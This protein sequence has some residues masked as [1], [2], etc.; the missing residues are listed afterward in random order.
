MLAGCKKSEIRIPRGMTWRSPVFGKQRAG[1][2]TPYQQGHFICMKCSPGGHKGK[3][4][5]IAGQGFEAP[6]IAHVPLSPQLS[7]WVTAGSKSQLNSSISTI[8]H[9]TNYSSEYKDTN[10]EFATLETISEILHGITWGDKI[11]IL[12]FHATSVPIMGLHKEVIWDLQGC[13]M[14]VIV[15]TIPPQEEWCPTLIQK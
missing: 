3:N 15:H 13:K 2:Q 6:C 10:P 8:G 14:F 9:I 7:F 11:H 5:G 4:E 1:R 12:L